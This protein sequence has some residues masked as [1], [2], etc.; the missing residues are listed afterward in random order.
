LAF[1]DGGVGG[2]QK[3]ARR[4]FI[5]DLFTC[6]KAPPQV[7]RF[8]E[9][10]QVLLSAGGEVELDDAMPVGRIGEFE[11]E[12]CRVIFGLLQPVAGK[13]VR[14]L[15]FDHCQHKISRVPQKIVGALARTATSL[16]T[17]GNNTAVGKTFLFADLIVVPAGGV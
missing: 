16:D 10:V 14:R 6:T 13:F 5:F 8:W 17:D 15:G 1:S 11:A 3:S 4:F 7:V 9:R 2:G 12:Y